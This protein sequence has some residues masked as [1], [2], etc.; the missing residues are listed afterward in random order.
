MRK[1]RIPICI[2]AMTVLVALISLAFL[3][4]GNAR[5]DDRVSI[6]DLIENMKKYNG[7]VVTIEG[8][9]IGDIMVRGD[10]AW[11]TVN[12]DAYSRKSLEEGGEFVGMSNAGIG[13][14]LPKGDT[15]T[16]GILGGYKNKGARVS[17]TGVFNR[18]CHE[19]GGDTD[20][21]AQRIGLVGKGYRFDHPLAYGQLFAAIALAAACAFLW[22]VR[23]NRMKKTVRGE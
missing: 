23:R 19:H 11:I 10:Y 7:E 2:S 9:A 4:P 15:E 12:D 8:E 22:N 6:V 18:A 20:I 5:A 13:V 16:I 1:T 3:F 14:W 17:V 21:H